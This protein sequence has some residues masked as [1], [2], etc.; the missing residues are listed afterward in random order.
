M[1][2][3]TKLSTASDDHTHEPTGRASNLC[4][5]PFLLFADRTDH[6]TD[7]AE[8]AKISLFSTVMSVNYSPDGMVDW[9]KRSSQGRRMMLHSTSTSAVTHP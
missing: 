4:H 5:V 8:T 3:Q 1:F 2:V 9:N 6:D 7:S